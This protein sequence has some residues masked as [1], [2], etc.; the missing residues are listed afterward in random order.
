MAACEA[1]REKVKLREW[2]GAFHYNVAWRV[3]LSKPVALDVGRKLHSCSPGQT[4]RTISRSQ[5]YGKMTITGWL[6][7]IESLPD[8]CCY[9][10]GAKIWNVSPLLQYSVELTLQFYAA[11]I[12]I[13]SNW[14]YNS[15]QLTLRKYWRG[16]S[17]LPG[18]ILPSD[19][20][21]C[22]R[23][24]PSTTFCQHEAK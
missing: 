19:G 8:Y 23:R 9:W 18:I 3:V 1:L 10:L 14:H 24:Q 7:C 13:Q 4:G 22:T 20:K 5:T 21:C 2:K 11:D 17:V 12:T 15:M 6:N 16:L